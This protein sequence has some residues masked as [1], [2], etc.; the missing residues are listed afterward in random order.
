MNKL[1][2]LALIAAFAVQ[3]LYGLTFTF[4]K[5]VMANGYVKPFGFIAL[6]VGGAALLFWIVNFFT[7]K[8][9]IESTGSSSC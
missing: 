6:R 2:I 5:D 1:R 7:P 8:E 9:K 4:A 3:L